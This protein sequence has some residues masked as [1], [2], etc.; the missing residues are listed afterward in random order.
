MTLKH[1][2]LFILE[3][4]NAVDPVSN[5]GIDMK[6]FSAGIFTSDP[7]DSTSLFPID[8]FANLAVCT[9]VVARVF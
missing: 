3:D 9:N 6:E 5:S 2:S 7:F 1:I 4:C 8:F